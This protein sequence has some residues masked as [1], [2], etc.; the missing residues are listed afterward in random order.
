MHRKKKYIGN[1]VLTPS[2]LMLSPRQHENY[3]HQLRCM[4]FGRWHGILNLSSSLIVFCHYLNQLEDIVSVCFLRIPHSK[5]LVV[6]GI[7]NIFC[8]MTF[9]PAVTLGSMSDWK[10]FNFVN[11]KEYFAFSEIFFFLCSMWCSHE[12]HAVKSM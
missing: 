12:C 11:F 9:D 3:P 1:R 8:P 10:G 5:I 2:H 6:Q 7:C 4:L